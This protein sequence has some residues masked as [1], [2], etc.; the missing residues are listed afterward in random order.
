[1]LAYWPTL[2]AQ[3]MQKVLTC[4]FALSAFAALAAY[5]ANDMISDQAIL[6][7]AVQQHVI[8]RPAE[9]DARISELRAKNALPTPPAGTELR[10][11]ITMQIIRE[12]VR[13]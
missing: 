7:M 10:Y 4:L 2:E 9:I 6:D 13:Q 1:M 8:V 12:K 3:D 5:A 11:Y